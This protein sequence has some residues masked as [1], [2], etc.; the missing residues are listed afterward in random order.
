MTMGRSRR[1]RASSAGVSKVESDSSAPSGARSCCRGAWAPSLISSSRSSFCSGLGPSFW[2][3][4]WTSDSVY[5]N[6]S[7]NSTL[8]AYPEKEETRQLARTAAR[9]G[10]ETA[11]DSLY[12]FKCKRFRNTRHT[13]VKLF[14]HILHY[15]WKLY[16]TV[17]IPGRTRCVLLH[18]DSSKHRTCPLN[19]CI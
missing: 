18:Y 4:A 15:Q 6:L 9:Y 7:P 10:S 16:W 17:A 8:A 12:A 2:R 1:L 11:L 3:A 19:K 13:I 14:S 5:P